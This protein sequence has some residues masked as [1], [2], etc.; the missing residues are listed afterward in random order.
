LED[1]KFK[2]YIVDLSQKKKKKKERRRREGKEEEGED[3][4]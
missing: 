3:I 4:F 2:T 1:H